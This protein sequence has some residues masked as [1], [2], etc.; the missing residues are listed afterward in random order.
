MELYF[1]SKKLEKAVYVILDLSAKKL[2]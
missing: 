2:Q 1:V